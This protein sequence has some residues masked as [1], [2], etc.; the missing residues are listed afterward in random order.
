MM[1]FNQLEHLNLRP[2]SGELSRLGIKHRTD[3]SWHN[4]T[5]NMN[6]LDVYEP[7][8]A[9]LKNAAV[10]LLEIGI[11]EGASLNLWQDYFTN[12]VAIIGIDIEENRRAPDTPP[13]FV[14]IGS[15]HDG[16]F[17]KAV[18]SEFTAFDIIIDD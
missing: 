5:S 8:F 7:Y 17:L 6:Y 18:K 16:R 2:D 15:Q 3:K 13:R 10:S 9:P 1:S 4:I 12:P 11:Y 14:R